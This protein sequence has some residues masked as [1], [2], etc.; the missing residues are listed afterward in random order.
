M[1]SGAKLLG[2]PIHQML[3]PL[4]LGVLSMAVIFDIIQL[5]T[6]QRV[7]S[8]S[9]YYMIIAGVIAGLVAAVF[10]L[11]DWLAVG[12]GTRAKRIGAWHGIGNVVVVVL[13]AASWFMRR[14]LPD[15]PSGGALVLS[16]AGA[17]VA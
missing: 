8:L 14:A 17:I 11:I 4:P 2:H 9:A 6:G 1:A 16:F 10:G 5:A 15:A 13:F 12:G 3:I 7:W